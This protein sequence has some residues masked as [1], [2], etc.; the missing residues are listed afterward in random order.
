MFTKDMC[1][2][3]DIFADPSMLVYRAA[4]YQMDRTL[5]TNYQ[6]VLTPLLV[7]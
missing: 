7:Y 1:C 3:G 6:Q 2:R 4:S 5:W